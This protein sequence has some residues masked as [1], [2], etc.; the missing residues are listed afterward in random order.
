MRILSLREVS[1]KL[2]C[3][4]VAELELE[5]RTF[6]KVFGFFKI[7]FFKKGLFGQLNSSATV[8]R[9]LD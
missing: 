7:F 5:S 2:C 4:K 1:P 6:Y 9:I 3:L 8:G